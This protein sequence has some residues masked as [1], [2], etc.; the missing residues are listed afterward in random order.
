MLQ[1]KID[2]K[3]K[4]II[5]LENVVLSLNYIAPVPL[6]VEAIQQVLELLGSLY[7]TGYTPSV[8]IIPTIT[9]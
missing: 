3:E 5:S 6:S 2:S 8:P 9:L 7:S 4:E 1:I